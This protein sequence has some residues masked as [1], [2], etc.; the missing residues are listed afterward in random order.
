MKKI[1]LVL[2]VSLFAVNAYSQNSTHTEYEEW[3]SSQD[4]YTNFDIGKYTTPDIV[5]N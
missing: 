1:I 4:E 5:R 3:K 2:A